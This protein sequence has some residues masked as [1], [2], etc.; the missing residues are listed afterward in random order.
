MKKMIYAIVL[1]ALCGITRQS[2]AQAIPTAHVTGIEIAVTYN[3]L[4]RNLTTIPTFWQQGGG[5]ELFGHL[6]QHWEAGMSITGEHS[7]DLAGSGVALSSVTAVFGPRYRLGSRCWSAFGHALIGESH[8]F[9][10][11]FPSSTGAQSSANTFA[12]QMGG[13]VDLKVSS[14]LAIRAFQ[15]QWLRTQFPNATTNVQNSLQLGTGVVVRF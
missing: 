3:P 15:A 12:L 10:S 7:G 9:D 14:H 13:G 5:F 6:T 11:V 8:G 4:Y 2:L 1:L